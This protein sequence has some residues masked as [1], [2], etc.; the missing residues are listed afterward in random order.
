MPIERKAV[1]FYGN[2]RGV[3]LVL[4]VLL[5][6]PDFPNNGLLHIVGLS[7]FIIGVDIEFQS[8]RRNI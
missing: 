2:Y 5:Q 4:L 6:H 7:I 8:L 3:F 1:S